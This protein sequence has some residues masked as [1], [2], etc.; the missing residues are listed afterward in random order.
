M[1]Q[2]SPEAAARLRHEL[3]GYERE[4]RDWIDRC[5]VNA[6]WYISD[7]IGAIREANIGIDEALLCELEA[8]EAAH[9]SCSCCENQRGAA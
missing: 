8:L 3:S 1:P 7:P 9:R 6:M 5:T 4:L 2:L